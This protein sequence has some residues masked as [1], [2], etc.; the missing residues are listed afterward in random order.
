MNAGK[1]VVVATLCLSSVTR[2]DDVWRFQDV[3][4]GGRIVYD[5]KSRDIRLTHKHISPVELDC[6]E[7][8]EYRFCL[9]GP[10]GYSFFV[11]KKMNV[12]FK[13]AEGGVAHEHV[14][15][16]KVNFFSCAFDVDVIDTAWLPV[17]GRRPL[18]TRYMYSDK[19]GIVSI[20]EHERERVYDRSEYFYSTAVFVRENIRCDDI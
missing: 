14:G 19:Y 7:R 9:T 8:S 16:V 11:P 18:V 2:A 3:L 5:V 6:G 10:F 17:E 4:S 12:G 1:V 20:A 15:R 13:W